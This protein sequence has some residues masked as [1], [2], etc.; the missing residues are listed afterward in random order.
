MASFNPLKIANKQKRQQQHVKTKKLK[1][2]TKRD[3]RLRRRR[4]EDKNPQLREARR[5]KNVPAT[6]DSKRT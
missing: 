6:I 5:A 1:E 3:E 2:N 4:T